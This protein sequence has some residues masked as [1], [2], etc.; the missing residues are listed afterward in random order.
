MVPEKFFSAID[1]ISENIKFNLFSSIEGLAL[2]SDKIK[3]LTI[4][5][6]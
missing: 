3:T 1:L 5:N 2:K 6:Y 4:Y